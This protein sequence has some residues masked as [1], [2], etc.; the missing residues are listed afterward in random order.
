MLPRADF[1]QLPKYV[2]DQLLARA[3]SVGHRLRDDATGPLRRRR[4]GLLDRAAVRAVVM[5]PPTPPAPCPAPLAEA[6]TI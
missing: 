4:T 1:E 6:S 3:E 2:G 5:A